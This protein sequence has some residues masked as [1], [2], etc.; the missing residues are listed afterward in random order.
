MPWHPTA[1][2]GIEQINSVGTAPTIISD[3]QEQQ[4]HDLQ[5]SWDNLHILV[6]HSHGER[7]VFS[8]LTA[9]VDLT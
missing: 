6:S 1:R 9:Q 7:C 3:L 2:Q 5:G 8:T 4:T